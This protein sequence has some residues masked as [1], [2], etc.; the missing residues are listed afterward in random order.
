MTGDIDEKI[1]DNDSEEEGCGS[2][3]DDFLPE[4]ECVSSQR[5]CGHH[6]NHCWTQ[7]CCH[8]CDGEMV[9]PPDGEYWEAG[10]WV[11]PRGILLPDGSRWTDEKGLTPAP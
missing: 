8:W 9:D 2:C 11:W 3:G 10:Y 4:G 6:C 7:D 1:T 5:P